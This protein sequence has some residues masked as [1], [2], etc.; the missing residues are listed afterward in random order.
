M[1]YKLPVKYTFLTFLE[2]KTSK[3]FVPFK[4]NEIATIQCPHF[5]VSLVVANMFKIDYWSLLF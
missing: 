5:R 2:M 1:Y 4:S 3:A